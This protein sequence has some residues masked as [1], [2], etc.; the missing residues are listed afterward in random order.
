[1]NEKAPVVTTGLIVSSCGAFLGSKDL[2]AQV[3]ALF[4]HI[5][6]T[7]RIDAVR[8]CDVVLILALPMSEPDIDSIIERKPIGFG[9]R[10]VPIKHRLVLIFESDLGNIDSAAAVWSSTRVLADSAAM[11]PKVLAVKNGKPDL[12]R[13]RLFHY[14]TNHSPDTRHYSLC[15][16]P[17]PD[18]WGLSHH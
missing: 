10:G 1:V 3:G 4:K 18:N 9:F 17:K 5:I 8:R 6:H 11:P 14:E 16:A 12:W 13:V 2:A 7:A 15:G